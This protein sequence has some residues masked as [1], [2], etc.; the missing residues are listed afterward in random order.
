MKRTP[1]TRKGGG[2]SRFFGRGGRGVTAALS[3]TAALLAGTAQAAQAA[4]D[5]PSAPPGQETAVAQLARFRIDDQTDHDGRVANWV[6]DGPDGTLHGGGSLVDDTVTWLGTNVDRS[7]KLDGV[8]AH[9]STPLVVATDQSFSVA[10][11]VKL[12]RTDKHNVVLSQDGSRV[13]GFYL[14][15]NTNGKWVFG[16][17]RSDSESAGWDSAEGPVA[18]A[19]VWTHLVGVF[20]A[21]LGEVR[22][23][24]NG[25]RAATVKRTASWVARGGVQAGRGLYAGEKGD[26]LAGNLDEIQVWR[27]ALSDADADEV[28]IAAPTARA[29]RCAVGHWLHVGGPEVKAVAAQALAGS[30]SD[31]RDSLA[32]STFT[33]NALESAR[34]RDSDRYLTA[35]RAQQQ[36]YDAWGAVV[37]PYTVWG[38]AFKT[39]WTVPP[40]G[41]DVHR[42]LMER[43]DDAFKEYFRN[44]PP[45]KPNQAALDQAL[46]IAAKMD[47]WNGWTEVPENGPRP[48]DWQ[49]KSWSANRVERFLRFGGYPRV[50]PVP[51]SPEFRMEVEAAKLLW[52]NCEA[53]D[54]DGTW[55]PVLSG[56]I[57]PPG[58]LHDAVTTA[59]A[60][61]NAELAAQATQRNNIVA[62][63][64]QAVSD[65]RAASAAM[66]E[67]Q[68][69]AWVAGQML[70]WQ[71]YW[72]K[73]PKTD[74]HYPKPAEFTKATAD[75]AAA[76]DRAGAQVAEARKAADSAR[77]Q[78]DKV[79]AAL[80]QAADIAKTNRTPLYRG[81]AYAQQSAQVAKASA[82]AAQA[83][84]KS[85]EA[86]ANAA[87]ATDADAAA[88]RSLAV[89]Q[90]EGLQAEFRRA[91]AQEAAA[92]A[93]ASALAAKTLADEAASYAAHAKSDRATAEKAETTA[94][95]A[96]DDAHAKRLV[97][98]K[99]R[100]KAADARKEA[101]SKRAEAEAAETRAAQQASEAGSARS[102]A[103]SAADTAHTKREEAEAA[104]GRARDAR[105]NALAAEQRRD[106]L[107]ARA[108]AA[109]ARADA[110]ESGDAAGAS[111][112]AAREAQSQADAA[113][114]AARKARA[115]ADTATAAAVQARAAATRATGAAQRSRAAAESAKAD[116]ATARAA[117]A[118]A[119]AAAADA[120][121]YAEA[122]ARNVKQAEVEAKTAA[123]AA[124]KAR[125]DAQVARKSAE[126]ATA[127]SARTAGAA[128]AAGAAASAARDSAL[129]A[130]DVAK[131]AIALGTPFQATD[132]SA[133]LAVLVGQNAKSLA[134]QQMAAADAKAAEA[135]K[136]AADAKTAAEKARADA[137]AAA[138]AAASAA[139]DAAAAAA[140]VKAARASA[141]AAAT[142]AAAA[143]KADDNATGYAGQAWTE[144]GRAEGAA[145]SAESEAKAARNSATDA[146]QDAASARSSASNAEHDASAARGAAKDADR[147]A[148]AAEGAAARAD[149]DA[150]EAQAAATRTEKQADANAS[151]AALSPD[152]PA[153]AEDVRAVP[154]LNEPNVELVGSC[155]APA[156]SRYCPQKVIVHITGKI[157]YYAVSC[158]DS[159]GS[160]CPGKEILDFVGSQPVK[161][162]KPDTI[163]V[164]VLKLSTELIKSLAMG[165]VGDF[166]DCARHKKDGWKT[167]CAW[168]IGTIV[169]PGGLGAAAKSIRGVRI[170]MR[171]GVGL[172]EA[173]AGL[174]AAKV[175][176][177]T[178]S[179]LDEA[180]NLRQVAKDCASLEVNS[181]SADTQ[182]VIPHG[183]WMKISEVRAGQLVRA[184]D[185]L[186][187][188][189]GLRRV[190]KVFRHHDT[191]LTDV[192]V[193][194]ASGR[195]SVLHTT[196][197]H[198]FWDRGHGRWTEASALEPGTSLLAPR[199]R[200]ATVVSVRSVAGGRDMYDLTVEEVH[201]F[202]VVAGATPVLVHNAGPG[203][204]SL[205]M[206]A[207]KI[208]HHFMS[209]DKNG[210]RHAVAFGIEGPY[211]K[212]NA[213][214]FI[215]AI[216]RLVKNPS[217]KVIRGTFRNTDAIHYVDPKSGLHAS[218]AANGPNVG[219]Y[220]G[221]WESSGEQLRYLLE[222]G[223]L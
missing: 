162:D 40:Y 200:Q 201:T 125:D 161:M 137:K 187:R 20:D 63:E 217:T 43:N 70:T 102:G 9:V 58:P 104:E 124:D 142:D 123:T 87:K 7:L 38:D 203:C 131:D 122:A 185:P 178:M 168:A 158:P 100:D 23:Y 84:Y 81:L 163:N 32:A 51:G 149:K 134:E 19:G 52:S 99:E 141:N 83:A 199:G 126:V 97:A 176:T 3:L 93:H 189:T 96:L 194:D 145:I 150:D 53:D 44:P 146:E 193:L 152:G 68:G 127:E 188:H 174:R 60:E 34:F 36:R 71:R 16:M 222:F 103:D 171:T 78:A 59:K 35:L 207:D 62:A 90:A 167:A 28:T 111:R 108:S 80:A 10:S 208:T 39:F 133:G 210:V 76:R 132:A 2:L 191:E 186:G 26:Y 65:V 135:A 212:A 172:E 119:H 116:E 47:P 213:K 195:T 113:S 198:L 147:D 117:A 57:P 151:T 129:Q 41:D 220:L 95:S 61:W 128:Y 77:S 115:D 1:G 209:P 154:V 85:T 49:V 169:I 190:T 105:D 12:S 6:A 223:K 219:M 15:A 177:A 106:V 144:A 30:S 50:A 139:T 17:P 120:I 72:L 215:D 75:L 101:D 140:S 202:Y 82:A 156:G 164:D 8:D 166:V 55:R 27:G 197:N 206:S 216:A 37:K 211:N 24:V 181:F 118:T 183:R 180:A 31:R 92:Q 67:A 48:E 54:P 69:Q 18:K 13:S 4:P 175:D 86:T 89:T 121:A 182:V 114:V 221:G 157:D 91:A 153:G 94:K 205:W 5:T 160:V 173:L 170:A 79:T 88:L 64:T 148:T 192:A 136:A 14:K 165:L 98:E 66:I 11:W 46:A 110:D 130:V 138:E 22:L 56:M 107:M 204:G 45:P 179:S 143:K 184:T 42:F 73:Q 21:G 74:I 155:D 218:F 25:V 159:D 109:E 112:T 29:D 33:T 196:D 214:L